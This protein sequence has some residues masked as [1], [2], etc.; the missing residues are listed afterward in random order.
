[1]K[2]DATTTDIAAAL[3]ALTHQYETI[4]HNLANANT[5]GFKRRLSVFALQDGLTGGAPASPTAATQAAVGIAGNDAVDFSQ[6]RLVHTGRSLDVALHG[7][8]F[9]VLETD[10]GDRYT[11]NGIFRTNAQGQLVDAQ[12]RTVAGQGGPLTIPP[13]VSPMQVEIAED[14]RILAAG[15]EI[16]QFRV[17]EFEDPKALTPVGENVFEAPAGARPD[18]AADTTVQQGFQE[19]SNVKAVHELVALIQVARTYEANVKIV[20][21]ASDR[22]KELI[23]V[24]MA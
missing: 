19:G 2:M 16:G 12:G 3:S 1:M 18:P 11:R 8:G 22:G 13:T 20:Q 21:A 4:A 15:A 9:F 10:R 5:V 14:G 23:R 7:K 24:A 6:G 17:V